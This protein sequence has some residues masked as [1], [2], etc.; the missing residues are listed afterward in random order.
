[1]PLRPRRRQK[2]MASIVYRFLFRLRPFFSDHIV[3]YEVVL[4]RLLDIKYGNRIP[5]LADDRGLQP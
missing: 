4:S 3:A 5:D 2:F 1:M